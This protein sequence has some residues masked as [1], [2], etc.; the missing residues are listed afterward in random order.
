MA[1]HKRLGAM[2]LVAM[3]AAV[4]AAASPRALAPAAGGLWSVS[5]DATGHGA[6]QICVSSPNALALWEHRN[7]RCTPEVIS[8][9]GTVAR[10]RYTCAD[11]GFGDTKITLIT[12]RTLR[13]ETQGISGGLPFHYQRHARRV[14]QCAASAPRSK[15]LLTMRR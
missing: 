11:G 7:G 9:Q 15:Q 14:G 6:E 13:I 5:P 3:S 8:D 4:L 12:P 1:K 2:S 10:I